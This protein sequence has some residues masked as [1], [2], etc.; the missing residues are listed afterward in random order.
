MSQILRIEAERMLR[1]FGQGRVTLAP[2]HLATYARLAPDLA[3]RYAGN[4][5][6]R[7]LFD[8]LAAAW[9]ASALQSGHARFLSPQRIDRCAQ[10]APAEALTHASDLLSD[11]RLKW[12]ARR[13]PG[14][15][16]CWAVGMLDD[17]D[18]AFVVASAPGAFLEGGWWK[19][20]WARVP[21]E[22][23]PMLAGRGDAAAESVVTYA[24]ERLEAPLRADLVKARPIAA[25]R[26]FSEGC[27]LT[28]EEWAHC[29]RSEPA[30]YALPLALWIKEQRTA[31]AIVPEVVLGAIRDAVMAAPEPVAEYPA[32][33]SLLSEDVR[34]RVAVS[35]PETALQKSARVLS[36]ATIDACAERA[37]LVAQKACPELLSPER[38]GWVERKALEA[39]QAAPGIPKIGLRAGP[40]AG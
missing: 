17:A 23:L 14:A 19:E 12:C 35:A 2:D 15:A 28:P 37:P 40:K 39:L 9:P 31:G 25:M 8:E 38:L 16:A 21:A 20:V 18:V 1:N 27:T 30:G 22:L 10:A 33:L 36:A 29:I 11:E 5:L 34:H 7:Q 32:I 13:E 26:A 4:R 24:L 6:Q 3:M